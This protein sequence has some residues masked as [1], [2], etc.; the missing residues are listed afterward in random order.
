MLPEGW[1]WTTLGEIVSNLDGA[2][3]PVKA[4]DRQGRQGPYRYYGASGVIDHVDDYL[5]EGEYLLIAED[6]AN[7]LSRSTPIAFPATG[8][9][10]VNN[11]AHVVQ[12]TGACSISYLAAY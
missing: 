10:W 8:R 1:S 5:F 6:G 3:V 11:H 2:R 12:P 9:F 4:T 7:L